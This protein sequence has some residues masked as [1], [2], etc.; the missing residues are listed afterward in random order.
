MK[1]NAIYLSILLSTA[2]PIVAHSQVAAPDPTSPQSAETAIDSDPGAIVVT[3]RRREE[4]A[5]DVPIA[6]SVLSGVSLAQQATFSLAQITQLA[7]TLQFTSSNPRNTSLNIRGLGVSYGLANDGLEQGVGF[8]VDG[9]YN[10]RPAAAAFDLLDVERVEI[11]R[12]PQ[13]TLFGKNTTAGAINIST[14]TPSFTP[15]GQFEG[16]GGTHRFGQLKASIS[17][18]LV[19]DRVAG[20]LSVGYTTRD[21]FVRSTAT[22][23]NVNDLD[24]F[25]ARG[26]LLWNATPTLNFR[27]SGDINIQNPDCCTQV[28]VR[29]GLTGK[30]PDKQYAALAAHYNY[31][32]PSLNY[33]D[34]LS[35]VDGRLNARSELGGLSLTGSLDLGAATLTSIT[36]WRY[37]NWQ[38]ANDRDYTSLDIIRQ[39]ANPVQ[40]NQYSQELRLSSNGKNTIDYTVGFYAYYQKLRGQNVTEWGAQGAY[41]LIGPK[42]TRT[43][44]GVTTTVDV[45]ENLID[46]YITTSKAVSTIQSYAGFAQATW[47]ITPRLHFTPGLRYTYEKK[48]ADYA[49]VVNGGLDPAT[50]TPA[51]MQPQIDALN[52]AKLSI[53]RPQAYSVA[54]NASAL[55]GDANFS[56]QP[57]PDVLIYAGYARGF[58]SGG[59]NLAGLP[60]NASNNPALNRAVVN[61]E[62]N[63]TY[64]AGLKTQWFHHL[65]TANF[66]IFRTDVKDFQANVVDNGPG[67]LR[68]YLANV[69][70][71]RSQGAEFDL[72]IAP[73]SGFSGYVR[74]AYTDAKYVS[75]KNAPCPLEQITNT[76]VVC[77]LSGQQLPGSSKWG[78]SAGTEYRRSVS[79]GSAYVGVDAN[80]RSSF[81]ADSSDSKYLRIDAYTLFN[82]RIGFASENGWEVFALVRNVFDKN[83][84]Q[85]L[86][87]Q[88]GNSGLISGLPGDPR[89]FQVT[90]R[91]RFGS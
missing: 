57:V 78:L 39:S 10:S 89:T 24:N 46:G 62:R 69:E 76:T 3:A 75:F 11:L 90:A 67:A 42:T 37:W 30:T 50:V 61:P 72:S 88:S 52:A 14:L 47:N 6:L 73:I 2:S 40:Q 66:A 87:P 12:G 26:Q 79:N 9:V 31:A 85:L 34:R 23:R 54:F 43:S 55:T 49:A 4:R 29:A 1:K 70:R 20:R 44:G 71:V 19:G 7:P 21:G 65:L 83:Y 60:F 8:Y 38:P 80:Y 51:Y 28:F 41:W 91:Y 27:L 48:D 16:S 36:A 64:E 25:V 5:Q 68:G 63:Q 53:F 56:W 18:P 84:L 35:D 81:Y 17:G 59:I 74:G 86:T 15:E 13:G 22:G 82:A 45:P 58:K 32:P 77:D 33:R